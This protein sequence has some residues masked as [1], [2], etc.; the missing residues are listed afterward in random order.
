[1]RN[2]GSRPHGLPVPVVALT[3]TSTGRGYWLVG[4]NGQIFAFGDAQFYGSTQ[5]TSTNQPIQTVVA[6][7]HS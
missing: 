2:F 3:R 5:G 4:V 6:S 1:A 7:R